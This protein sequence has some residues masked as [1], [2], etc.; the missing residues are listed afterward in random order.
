MKQVT[1]GMKHLS[2]EMKRWCVEMKRLF[3]TLE[4]F[5]WDFSAH[6]VANEKRFTQGQSNG[7]LTLGCAGRVV[8]GWVVI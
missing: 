3:P 2:G 6:K 7:D 4:T 5:F 8:C 1:E